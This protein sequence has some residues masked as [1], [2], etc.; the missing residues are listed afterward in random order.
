[1]DHLNAPKSAERQASPPYT[2]IPGSI[3][4]T[5]VWQTLLQHTLKFIN[6]TDMSKSLMPSS[7]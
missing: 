4:V 6:L 2:G 7:N 3:I 1:M 5:T